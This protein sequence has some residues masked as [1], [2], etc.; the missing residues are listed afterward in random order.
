M[1]IPPAMALNASIVR[2]FRIIG[3]SDMAV[4]LLFHIGHCRP[5]RASDQ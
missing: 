3:L 4:L 5:C 2:R 1:L